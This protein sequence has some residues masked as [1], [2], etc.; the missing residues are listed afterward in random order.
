[1]KYLAFWGDLDT[2]KRKDNFIIDSQKFRKGPAMNIYKFIKPP[3]Y[4]DIEKNRVANLMHL[5]LLY[6]GA[7]IIF[8]L[9]GFVVVGRTEARYLAP[10]IIALIFYGAFYGLLKTGY[11][12]LSAFLFVILSYLALTF[13]I[14]L[15]TDFKEVDSF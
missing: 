1:M 15:L 12:Y 9:L 14:R 3:V 6:N 4:E 10:I 8:L 2:L 5:L 13:F 11:V 7:F